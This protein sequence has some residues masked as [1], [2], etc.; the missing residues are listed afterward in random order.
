LKKREK[1]VEIYVVFLMSEE[2]NG[3]MQAPKTSTFV[4]LRHNIWLYVY[5]AKN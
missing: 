1:K 2:G 4:S 5:D 3:K